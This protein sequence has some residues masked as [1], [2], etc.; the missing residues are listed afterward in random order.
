MYVASTR[1][2]SAAARRSSHA[3]RSRLG[4][5]DTGADPSCSSLRGG[6]S[7]ADALSI[8]TRSAAPR[9]YSALMCSSWPAVS[10]PAFRS[11]RGSPT[12]ASTRNAAVTWAIVGSPPST[13]R[14]RS[15]IALSTEA[16]ADARGPPEVAPA[17]PAGPPGADLPG[18]QLRPLGQAAL[19]RG[20]D[21]RPPLP[22]GRDQRPQF[23]LAPPA[24][25][26]AD[27]GPGQ[28]RHR[29]GRGERDVQQPGQ[30]EAKRQAARGQRGRAGHLERPT[31]PPLLAVLRVHPPLVELLRRWGRRPARQR[32]GIAVLRGVLPAEVQPVQPHRGP[33]RRRGRG[34]AV[35]GWR[36]TPSCR[37]AAP[38]PAGPAPADPA[39]AALVP[40]ARAGTCRQRVSTRGRGPRESRANASAPSGGRSSRGGLPPLTPNA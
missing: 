40:P 11:S 24:A 21:L 19:L 27:R 37:P 30:T 18:M 17:P 12:W 22:L 23:L 15:R 16:G 33:L 29:P 4:G 25:A 31:Q 13:P 2:P 26:A 32:T 6:D 34:R 3:T 28:A 5:S 14:T 1:L 8:T 10:S 9:P 36:R 35:P 39:L 20:T 38:A 7:I